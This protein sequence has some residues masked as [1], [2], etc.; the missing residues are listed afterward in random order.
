MNDP[1]NLRR[2]DRVIVH[3]PTVSFRAHVLQTPN[4]RCVQVRSLNGTL[5]V[6][7]AHNVE[8]APLSAAELAEQRQREAS[9]RRVSP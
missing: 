1:V 3:T 5:G 6:V 8:L 9:A 7:E 4:P 2:G